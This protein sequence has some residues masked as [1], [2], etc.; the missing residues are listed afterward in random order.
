MERH[1][2]PSAIK[3]IIN[4]PTS[5]SMTQ[6]AIAAAL[7]ADGQSI[8]HNPS[9]CDDSLAAMSIAVG[10]GARVEPQVN[11]MKI[12][13]SSV[14]KESKLNCGESG[15]AIRMF[16][17][18]VALYPSEVTLVGANSLKKR[19][20]FMIEEALTQLG[21]KCTSSGGFLPLT[22]Q[23]PLTGGLIEIDGSVSSQLLTGL[24]MALPLASK[25]SVINVN[26]LKSKPYIDMTI[27]ILKSFGI[28][29]ENKDYKL[30]HIP[31]NQKYIPYDYTVEGDWSGGAFLLV[32]G[33]I[34][35]DLTVNGLRRDSLQSDMSVIHAL[36]KAGARMTMSE[37]KIEISKSEL[38]AFDFNA[39]ESPDLFPPLVALASY[40]EGVSTI[41]GVSRLIFKE[42]DR[43]KTL[44]EEFGKLNIRIEVNDDIMSVTGSRPKSARVESHE[45]HRIA[46]ALAVASL[47][48][49]G[50][51]SIRDSQ[52][53]AK[54][55]P[56][57][58]TDLRQ[59][60]AVIHE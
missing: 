3:G 19:P 10:L 21:V 43:A 40:C 1:V 30:F 24:L 42:S 49:T 56:D 55:Y 45:D 51:V 25:D 37:N 12:T 39:T 52:C 28:S 60:G 2:E 32:A 18:I 26:N 35:G 14:L 11:Q 47:G 6:R 50:K 34:N 16:S 22:I 8:I 29:V 36:E 48:A 58:F 33:A 44:K 13:G 23:G 53:V 57:F 15:L 46:M 4:A 59:L 41:K 27:Q 5:K 20:M 31:G 54:S 9:Y 7:L 38:K 17:P